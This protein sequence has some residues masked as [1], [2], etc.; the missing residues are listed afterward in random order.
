MAR[1][2]GYSRDTT[3]TAD[4]GLETSKIQHPQ[5]ISH[6][7]HSRISNGLFVIILSPWSPGTVFGVLRSVV[8]ICTDLW[9]LAVL[10]EMVIGVQEQAEDGSAVEC[11]LQDGRLIVKWIESQ[12]S[13]SHAR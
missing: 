9:L 1:A 8:W 6:F 11:P 2:R 10:G 7:R 13:S 12:P 4:M 3:R 5:K